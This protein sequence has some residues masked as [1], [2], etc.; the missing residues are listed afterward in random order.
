MAGFVRRHLQVFVG[1][2]AWQSRAAKVW[3]GRAFGGKTG[4]FT[5]SMPFVGLRPNLTI[6]QYVVS[7]NVL[8]QKVLPFSIGDWKRTADEVQVKVVES[9]QSEA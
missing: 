6:K 2:A 9:A 1:A 4:F 5:K 8:E 3:L 7:L